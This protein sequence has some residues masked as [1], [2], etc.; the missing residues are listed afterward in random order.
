M[1]PLTCY[2]PEYSHNRVI[3]IAKP[4][5]LTAPRILPLLGAYKW[6]YTTVG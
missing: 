6:A 4:T 3:S 2:I 5:N 1:P